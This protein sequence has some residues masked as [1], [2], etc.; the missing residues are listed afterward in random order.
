MYAFVEQ[1]RTKCTLLLSADF[2]TLIS[3]EHL[4]GK[5]YAMSCGKKKKRRKLLRFSSIFV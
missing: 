4:I 5:K 3:K 1:K 2:L